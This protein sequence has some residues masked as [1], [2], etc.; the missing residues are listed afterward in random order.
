[1]RIGCRLALVDTLASDVVTNLNSRRQ[2]TGGKPKDW[3]R[4]TN[5]SSAAGDGDGGDGGGDQCST[6]NCA[7]DAVFNPLGIAPV[8]MKLPRDL[9]CTVTVAACFGGNDISHSN[10]SGGPGACCAACARQLGCVGY[11]YNPAGYDHSNCF[12]KKRMEHGETKAGCV[13]GGATT[14]PGPGPAPGPSPPPP[15]PPHGATMLFHVPTDPGEHNDVS[16]ANPDIVARLSAVLNAMRATAVQP[17]DQHEC[18]GNTTK[19]VAAGTYVTP[20][21]TVIH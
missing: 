18:N 6:S 14:P 17:H 16:A 15:P 12:L 2:G 3:S 11:S 21:C 10:V 7:V 19:T 20:A 5:I 1:M 13:S 8:A 4:P 9:N